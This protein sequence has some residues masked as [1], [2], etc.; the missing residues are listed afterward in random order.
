MIDSVAPH[1]DRNATVMP[2]AISSIMPGRRARISPSP[3][4]RN[5]RPPQTYMT[6]PSTAAI[7]PAPPARR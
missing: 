1:D 3:P 6:M 7:Q 2:N 4:V 5:G